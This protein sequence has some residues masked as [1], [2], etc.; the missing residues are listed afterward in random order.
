MAPCLDQYLFIFALFGKLGADPR[1]L[2]DPAKAEGRAQLRLLL[3]Q[4][5]EAGPGQL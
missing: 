5:G 1:L 2:P 4:A 3:K